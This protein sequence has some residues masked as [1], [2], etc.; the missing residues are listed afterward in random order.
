M[1]A[2]IFD[3]DIY[4]KYRNWKEGEGDDQSRHRH[5]VNWVIRMR[6]ADRD[7]THKWLQKWNELHPQSILERDVVLQWKLGNRGEVGTWK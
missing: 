2:G 3:V 4:E 7:K 6:I 5:L 1:S